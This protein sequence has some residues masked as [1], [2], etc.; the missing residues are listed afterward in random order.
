MAD[1]LAKKLLCNCFRFRRREPNFGSQAAITNSNS[2]ARQALREAK[3]GPKAIVDMSADELRIECTRLGIPL[4]ELG[5][6]DRHE[7]VAL[8]L[9]P[10]QERTPLVTEYSNLSVPALKERCKQTGCPAAVYQNV[11][12]KQ[13]LINLLLAADGSAKF[14]TP[15]A[16]APDTPNNLLLRRLSEAELG[17]YINRQVAEIKASGLSQAETKRQL[18]R[19]TLS[20]HPDKNPADPSKANFAFNHLSTILEKG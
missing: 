16:A 4:W 1:V 5:D 3:D 15:H 19:L 8:L 2:T 13:E 9:N 20:W 7:L 11:S 12:E 6:M 17:E 10:T 14:E 18:R